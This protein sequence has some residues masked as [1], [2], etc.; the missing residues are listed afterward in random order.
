MSTTTEAKDPSSARV[1]RNHAATVASHLAAGQ[2]VAY[3]VAGPTQKPE[4]ATEEVETERA[5]GAARSMSLLMNRGGTSMPD[6][7]DPPWH[8]SHS[9]K[10]PLSLSLSLSLSNTTPPRAN[11]CLSNDPTCE[12]LRYLVPS[13]SLSLSLTPSLCLPLSLSPL[14]WLQMLCLEQLS[15]G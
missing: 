4:P 6:K 2:F 7:N 9:L 11:L 10:R 14:H 12:R 5:A 13:L 15:L 3:Q 8:D 1:I